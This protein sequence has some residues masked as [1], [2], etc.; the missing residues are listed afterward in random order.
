MMSLREFDYYIRQMLKNNEDDS[1]STAC[2]TKKPFRF[3]YKKLIREFDDKDKNLKRWLLGKPCIYTH[4]ITEN[5]I[6][7]EVGRDIEALYYFLLFC[8]KINNAEE[9]SEDFRD[10]LALVLSRSVY[11]YDGD[12]A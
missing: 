3:I 4:P 2:L 10:Y 8:Y 1:D 11:H 7:V 9:I 6:P 5:E 12:D